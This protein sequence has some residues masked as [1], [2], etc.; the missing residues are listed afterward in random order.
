M[1]T[2]NGE[3]NFEKFSDRIKGLIGTDSVSA[4]ARRIGIKQAAVDRYV[5]GLREPNADALRTIAT[6]CDVSTDWL[7]G[8]SATPNGVTDTDWRNRALSAE[9]KL[10]KVQKALAHALKGFEE[11][12]DAVR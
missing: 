1:S 3:N 7:L 6:A 12:Q 9:R 5:K 8:I 4:F 2:P 11:L 10:D